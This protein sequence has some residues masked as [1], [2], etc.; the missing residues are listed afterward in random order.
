MA[1][2]ETK[3]PKKSKNGKRKPSK[4]GP[5][6]PK[7]QPIIAPAAVELDQTL[8]NDAV[9]F[10]NEKANEHVYKAYEEIGNYLLSQIDETKNGLYRVVAK[11]IRDFLENT[12]VA[13]ELSSAL[14]KLSLEIKTEIRFVPNDA[15]G[16]GAS[17]KPE[18]VRTDVAV[19]AARAEGNDE[20]RPRKRAR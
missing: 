14:S 6:P 11:E 8:V 5:I 2:Q 12:N 3:T 9:H 7:E 4:R 10:I 18:V 16:H 13:D 17:T 20:P 1:K 19:G 15:A